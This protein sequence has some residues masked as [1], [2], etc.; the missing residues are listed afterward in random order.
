MVSPFCSN[1]TTSKA[2]KDILGPQTKS[3]LNIASKPLMSQT[4]NS[5][6]TINT[7][8][9]NQADMATAHTKN[10][11]NAAVLRRIFFS[12]ISNGNN[13]ASSNANATYMQASSPTSTTANKAPSIE[14][15]KSTV[16]YATDENSAVLLTTTV[17]PDPK[18]STSATLP[19][20]SDS[21]K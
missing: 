8:D 2:F 15:I 10:I 7:T 18:N 14:S 4:P 3:S 13:T 1:D 9:N 17:P 5:R 6:Q 21:D 19:I 20:Q 16:P 12:Q 11:S